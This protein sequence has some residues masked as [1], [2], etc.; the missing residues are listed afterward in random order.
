MTEYYDLVLG[1]IPLVVLGLG[2][3]LQVAGFAQ[4]TAVT[5]GGLIGVG[6]VLHALFVRAPVADTDSSP[7][8][9]RTSVPAP[10][11]D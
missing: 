4:T 6:L 1:L 2:G 8:Q 5:V 3:G 7:G 10:N 9:E 11:A